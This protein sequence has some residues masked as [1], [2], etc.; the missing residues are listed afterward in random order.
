[1]SRKAVTIAWAVAG[2]VTA[3]LL[4]IYARGTITALLIA[5]AIAY[6]LEPLV[7]ALERRRIPRGLAIILLSVTMVA[8]ATAL[9]LWIVPRVVDQTRQFIE[10]VDLEAL[11]ARLTPILGQYAS[12]WTELFEK[13]R[14]RAVAYLQENGTTLLMPAVKTIGSVT[15]V[16]IHFVARLFELVLIPVL[17]FYLLRDSHRLKAYFRDLIPPSRQAAVFG[18]LADID[19]V[20]RRFIRGQVIVSSILGVLYAVGLL[21]VGT[22]LAVPIGVLA[23]FASLIPY[24]GFAFG[25][26]MGLILTFLQYG[27]WVRLR[28]VVLVFAIVQLLEGTVITPRIIGESTGLHPAVVLLALMLGGSIFG[29]PGLL[30]AVPVAAALAVL[31]RAGLKDLRRD[32]T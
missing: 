2:L 24:A 8:G 23:G 15:G 13:L 3:I 31:L 26:T 19:A 12:N 32:W 22:P 25:L 21:I 1:M 10:A 27:S 5:M 16:I 11:N 17:S 14:V 20:L 7:D 18:L 28:F 30:V 9:V 29:M 6:I 4:I